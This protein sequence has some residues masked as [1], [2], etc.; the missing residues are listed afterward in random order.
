MDVPD[1]AQITRLLGELTQFGSHAAVD[2]L[3]KALYPELHRL[4]QRLFREE[5]TDH[6]LQPT[7]LVHEAYLRLVDQAN[8]GWEGRSH[9]LAIAAKTMRRILID[10]ARGKARKRRGGGERI[11]DLGGELLP[12]EF[13]QAELLEID[14][15]LD[16]LAAFDARQAQVVEMRFFGGMTIAEIAEALNVSKRT[17]EQDWTHAKAWLRLALAGGADP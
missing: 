5:R 15:A 8:V 7:A 4:A 2:Q 12:T 9:F 11:M 14:E 10:Y 3:M 13:T 6:T 1:K 17:I 16:K